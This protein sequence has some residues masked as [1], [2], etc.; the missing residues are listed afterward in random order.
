MTRRRSLARYVPI[1]ALALLVGFVACQFHPAAADDVAAVQQ[2]KSLSQAFRSAAKDIL[3]TVVKVSTITKPRRVDGGSYQENPFRGSPFEEYFGDQTPGFRWH[4]NPEAPRPGLGSGVII[5]PSG[6]I[7]TNNHVV[8]DSDKVIV[9]LGDGRR[10][11]AID[12]KTDEKSDLAVIRIKADEPLPAAKLGNSDQLEI[13][14]WV[15]AVG[16]PFELEQT[17]S[18]GII[19]AK[20]RS[21]GEMGRANFIQTDAAINPGNS[22]GPLVNLDGEVV[23]I[24]T[25]I[26]SRSGGYQ[27]I[28]FAIPVNVAKWVSPQLVKAGTVH[29]AYLGVKIGDITADT[30]DQY[31]VKPR[32]GVVVAEVFDGS[33]AAGAGLK[34]DDIILSVDGNPIRNASDLQ[35]IVEQLADGSRHQMRIIRQGKPDSLD[36]VVKS[37][38][39][40]YGVAQSGAPD[41]YQSR[42]LG[43]AVVDLSSLMANQLGLAEDKGALVVRA[44]PG[45][46]AYKAGLREG[47]AITKVGTRPVKSAADFSSAMEKESLDKG[48][49]LEVDTQNGSRVVQLKN[50]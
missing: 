43:L 45:S 24:N 36:V 10:F 40:D 46:L 37:M 33:P 27:G 4:S 44:A 18:A 42:A 13:G 9:Q 41:I 15:I 38:P 1:L 3:P 11:E 32:Q 31:G 29:R 22:G 20:G 39:D 17:V 30:A 26:F 2:A 7:L 14:D 21:L 19:S 35:S 48:I 47:M 16:S 23:G 50:P 28:G 49:R 8:E 25:A 5:D 6:V 12:I 34:V